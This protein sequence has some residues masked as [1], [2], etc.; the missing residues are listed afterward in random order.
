MEQLANDSTNVENIDLPQLQS[1]HRILGAA[2]RADRRRMEQLSSQVA[3]LSAALGTQETLASSHAQLKEEHQQQAKQ[4]KS[5]QQEA[6]KTARYRT[7]ARQQEA[8]INKLE[9]LLQQSLN[10]SKTVRAFAPSPAPRPHR[11]ATC[12]TG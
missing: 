8:I 5:L 12:P 7:T 9:S 2:Y 6:K 11:T 3:Q 1:R 10:E 4:I